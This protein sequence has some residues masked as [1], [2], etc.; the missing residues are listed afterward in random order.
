[1]QVMMPL[2][3]G[4]MTTQFSSGLALYFVISN[5]IGMGTQ[6]LVSH[7]KLGGSDEAVTVTKEITTSKG[8]ASNARKRQRRKAKR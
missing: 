1:M 4:Y 8:K 3:F 6:L 5:L 7:T 2:M